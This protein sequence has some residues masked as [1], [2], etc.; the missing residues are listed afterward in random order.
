MNGREK[1]W[2]QVFWAFSLRCLIAWGRGEVK[3]R[4]VSLVSFA[5]RADLIV[6]VEAAGRAS[7]WPTTIS[8]GR[9][10]GVAAQLEPIFI[11]AAIV[12]QHG[13]G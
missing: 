11:S 8:C 13:K 4:D 9:V 5:E 12:A 10:G 6:Q 3:D 2:S 7:C 1:A